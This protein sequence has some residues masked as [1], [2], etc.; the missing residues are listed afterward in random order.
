ML[1]P[2]ELRGLPAPSDFH[3]PI[4]TT[5]GDGVKIFLSPPLACVS[6]NNKK[7]FFV[8]RSWRGDKDKKKPPEARGGRHP[9]GFAE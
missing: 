4:T 1:A 6:P 9:E 2:S 3:R 7:N 5:G 8:G